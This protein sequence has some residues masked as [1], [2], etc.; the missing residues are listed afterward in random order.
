MPCTCNQPRI[1]GVD[2]G[3]DLKGVKGVRG[4]HSGAW[5]PVEEVE[6]DVDTFCDS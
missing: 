6:R 4:A 3:V 5:V 1:E 2:L